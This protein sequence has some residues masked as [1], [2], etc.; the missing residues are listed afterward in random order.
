MVA[1]LRIHRFM[2]LQQR[3]DVLEDKIAQLHLF[4]SGGQNN[5]GNQVTDGDMEDVDNNSG[6]NMSDGEFQYVE[7]ENVEAGQ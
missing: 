7:D 4:R 1:Y 2:R 6:G 5:N 3:I